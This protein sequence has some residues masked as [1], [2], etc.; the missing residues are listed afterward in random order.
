V[1]RSEAWFAL[2]CAASALN[3]P[4]I[5]TIHEIGQQDGQYFI[6]MELLEGKTLRDRILGRPLP[7]D[8]LVAGSGDCRRSGCGASERDHS[9]RY[10]AD[11][12]LRD[13]TWARED[14]GFRAK[15][16]GRS[17]PEFCESSAFPCMRQL[18]YSS[19]S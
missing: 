5:C 12:H 8:E 15:A 3:H 2:H 13:R 14:P 1:T 16:E 11:K 18:N 9:S 10:Q 7:T 4:N 19:R 6:V 17:S